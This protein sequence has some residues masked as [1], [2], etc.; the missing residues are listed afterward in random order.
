MTTDFLKKNGLDIS[1]SKNK[2][3]SIVANKK[4]LFTINGQELSISNTWKTAMIFSEL[5]RL[6]HHNY[7]TSSKTSTIP[8]YLLPKTNCH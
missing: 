4:T 2:S 3:L 7:P 8:P 1:G 5:Q 6:H